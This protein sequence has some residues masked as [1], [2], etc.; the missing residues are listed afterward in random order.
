MMVIKM[1]IINKVEGL[2]FKQVLHYP[3]IQVVENKTVI[4]NDRCTVEQFT[5]EFCKIKTPHICYELT[6]A[7]LR[8][9]EYGDFVIRIESDGVKKIEIVGDQN[10]K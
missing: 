8:V 1:E 5:E 7:N 4:I 10:E 9:K 6:G 2:I 3:L